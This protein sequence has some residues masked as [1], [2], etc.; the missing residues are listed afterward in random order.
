MGNHKRSTMMRKMVSYM[1]AFGILASSA[2]AAS[3]TVWNN[4]DGNG[5]VAPSVWYSYPEK[6]AANANG[7]TGTLTT[8]TDKSKVFAATVSTT[9]TSSSAGIGFNWKTATTNGTVSLADYAGLCVTYSATQPVQVEFKQPTVKDY[10]YHGIQ[11]PAK[12]AKDTLFIAF[13]DLAQDPNWGTAVDFDISKQQSVQFAYKQSIAKETGVAKNTIT[14]YGLSLGSSCSQHAPV[15]SAGYTDGDANTLDE[16]KVLTLDLNKVFT[17]EDDDNLTFAVKILLG[18]GATKEAVKLADSLYAKNGILNLTTGSNP[19]GTATVTVTATD[20]TKKSATYEFTVEAIDGDN[21]PVAVD[22]EYSTKEETK[23]TRTSLLGVFQNDYDV[24]D[25][26]SKNFVATLK[27]TTA[28]GELDFDGTTGAFTYI[29]EENFF[30]VDVFTYFLTSKEDKQN[31]NVATVSITVTNVDDPLSVIVNK[32]AFNFGEDEYK[33][34]LPT[35]PAADTITL[36]EDFDPVTVEIPY[37]NVSFYDPDIN[38]TTVPVKVK[39]SGIV[40]VLYGEI[41][42]NHVI[43]LDPIENA[44]GTAK[45]TLYAADG[46]DTV[47]VHFYVKVTPVADKPVAKDDTYRVI[48]DS[49]NKV[50]AKNGVLANDVNP[51]GKST[52]KAYLAVGSSLGT[53]KLEED[54]SFTYK[55]GEEEGEDMFSYYVVNAEG[56][57]SETATVALTILYKNKAPTPV[58]GVADTV[59]RLM[60]LKEGFGSADAATFLKKEMQTWFTDDLDDPT[61]LTFTARSDDSL[62][63]PTLVTSTGAIKIYSVK[64]ACGTTKIII[65]AKDSQG[66]VGELEIP[67][68]IACKNDRPVIQ[69]AIDTLYAGIGETWDLKY[70]LST[71]VMDPDGDELTFKIEPI[72]KTSTF[73]SVTME[74]GILSIVSAEDSVITPNKMYPIAITASDAEFSGTFKLLVIAKEA[75]TSIAPVLASPKANWQSTILADRGT[76]ALFD[77][78]GRVMWKAKLPVSEEAV[79]NAAAQVQGRKILQVNKQTWTIK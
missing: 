72:V 71:N 25:G 28:H 46:K 37:E 78:Q 70:D 12:T 52:L 1:G 66:A 55:A 77:M 14:L 6:G 39:S 63:A 21:A 67:A 54:G 45:V 53:V 79:R 17:D 48:Q 60:N 75:P 50:L 49:L 34:G 36:A 38:G 20:P 74:N 7:A 8:G 57:T 3:A 4:E 68:S 41:G 2:F 24:D 33:L 16:G 29:P 11:I 31:S 62:L 43:Q 58:A 26:T 35:S 9:N 18:T 73:A 61:K 15:L 59:K 51:D 5:T 23:L 65:E 13:S 69:K 32:N 42:D 30:G 76:V 47:S 27:T 44:N 10:N 56:D 22:D 64:Y 19:A 40:K